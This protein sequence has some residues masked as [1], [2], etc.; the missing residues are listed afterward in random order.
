MCWKSD[1]VR[2]RYGRRR[3]FFL[4]GLPLTMISLPL[5]GL[6]P[7]FIQGDARHTATALAVVIVVNVFMQAVVDI[8]WGSLEPLYADTFRQQQL[9]RASSIRQIVSQI[10]NFAMVTWVLAW[11]DRSE[12]DPYLFSAG[13]VGLS[14]LLMIFVIRE[15][16]T[17][18]PQA[19]ARYSPIKHLGIL[20]RSADHARLAFVCASNLVLPAALFLFT[21][22]Y[23]TDTLGLSKTELGRAQA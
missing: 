20:F 16:P 12:L 4:A 9:G 17:G 13:C 10:A 14:L 21:P 11:A 1:F 2:T 7:V 22:L 3:P 23:V 6:L 19:P 18:D 8:N 5:V 15:Q